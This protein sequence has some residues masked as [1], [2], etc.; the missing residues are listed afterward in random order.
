MREAGGSLLGGGNDLSF[1]LCVKY[2][3]INICRNQVV[4]LRFVHITISMLYFN[5]R[6]KGG[7]IVDGQG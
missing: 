3:G 4:L 2:T 5:I 1:D 7:D 6:R